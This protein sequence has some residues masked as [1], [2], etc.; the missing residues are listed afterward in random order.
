MHAPHVP[1][2]E[3]I[4]SARRSLGTAE[5]SVEILR[6]ILAEAAP[7]SVLARTAR[8]WLDQRERSVFCRRLELD[9][10]LRERRHPAAPSRIGAR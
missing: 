3:S 1:S 6:S 2:P 8:A 4:A 5:A 10:L 9:A 7:A